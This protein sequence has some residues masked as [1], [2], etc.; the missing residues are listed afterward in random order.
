MAFG[1][2]QR[3]HRLRMEPEVFVIRRTDV[4]CR[5]RQ[6][7]EKALLIEFGVQGDAPIIFTVTV[8]IPTGKEGRNVIHLLRRLR[9]ARKI[10][11]QF[12]L[13]FLL[14]VWLPQNVPAIIKDLAIAI[15]QDSVNFALPSIKS[16]HGGYSR[17]RHAL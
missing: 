4:R 13:K 9:W 3:L 14:L 6:E 5:Q 10:I 17:L 2:N 1:V 15:E 16:L 11:T 12:I 8:P 7:V